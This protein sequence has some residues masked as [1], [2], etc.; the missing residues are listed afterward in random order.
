MLSPQ[1]AESIIYIDTTKDLWEDLNERF[2]KGDYFR[3]SELLQE[4]HSIRQGERN[5][6]QFFID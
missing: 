6:S 1:I 5:V 4:I 2:F 3:I